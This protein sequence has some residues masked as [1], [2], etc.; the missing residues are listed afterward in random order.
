MKAGIKRITLL[1]I[2]SL[3]VVNSY[4]ASKTSD[5]INGVAQFLID[6]ANDNYLYIFEKKIK[7]SKSMACYFPETKNNLEFA[8]L[9]HLLLS[10][11][12]WEI[13]LEKDLETLLVRA[14]VRSIEN[15]LDV[16]KLSVTLWGEYIEAL[17][18]LRYQYKGKPVLLHAL[19]INKDEELTKI[20]NSFFN[21]ANIV[22]D[23]FEFFK[24]YRNK[25]L[26]QTPN[27]SYKEFR[28]KVQALYEIDK[29]LKAIK[30]NFKKHSDSIKY[31][32]GSGPLKNKADI[33]NFLDKLT[34]KYKTARAKKIKQASTAENEKEITDSL[35]KLSELTA[36]YEDKTTSGTVK[37]I[38]TLSE[39]KKRGGFSDIED[40]NNLKKYI[41]FFAQIGDADQA[42]V[43][44]ILKS[45]TLP[46]VSFYEKRNKKDVWLIGAYL[47][48]IGGSSEVPSGEDD[49]NNV[50]IFA[51][52]GLEYANGNSDGSS[53]SIM[54]APFDFGYP[55][56]L[57]LNG[58]DKDVNLDE[59]VAPSIVFSYGVADW[60]LSIGVG[61]QRGRS[62]TATS[63]NEE[64]VFI[65]F[66]FDMPLWVF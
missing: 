23:A 11:D 14:T 47:G 48:V 32:G 56:S 53:W 17:Q 26:C 28:S 35:N 63:D 40:F 36:I 3:I 2:L 1:I 16:S 15:T 60:P 24:K 22:N 45:Y 42:G 38:R 37:A 66:S 61:Y 62:F 30:E 59:I 51:P 18:Q 52:I 64:K 43:S 39:V 54:L 29:R 58:I 19:P 49:G 6:R 46:S 5:R 8:S 13:S 20:V 34:N 10:T 55:V 12:L 31:V 27:L 65:H 7:E 9:K 21:D 25:P 57:K 50:G 44:A 4:A 33:Y 41:L